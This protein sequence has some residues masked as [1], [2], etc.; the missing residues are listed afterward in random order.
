MKRDVTEE[1]IS[2]L[3]D[4]TFTITECAKS[5]DQYMQMVQDQA[6]YIEQLKRK[7]KKLKRRVA[8]LEES[9]ENMCQ[10]ERNLRNKLE[11][12]K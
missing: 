9:C 3:T 6:G 12:N 10:V 5:L 1:L 8:D 11:G 2:S 7:N 4:Y